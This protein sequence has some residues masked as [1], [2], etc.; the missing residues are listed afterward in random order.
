MNGEW[1]FG[2]KSATN[3]LFL[4]DTHDQADSAAYGLV[5]DLSGPYTD[6][7]HP[8]RRGMPENER[9]ENHVDRRKR[10]GGRFV[11]PTPGVLGG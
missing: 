1:G 4:A 8:V 7:D 6:G 9:E 2:N 11:W 5:S 10:T 3:R